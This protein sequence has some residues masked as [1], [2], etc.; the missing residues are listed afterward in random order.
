MI[1]LEGAG[2]SLPAAMTSSSAQLIAMLCK[3]AT[4]DMASSKSYT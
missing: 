3:A 4:E 1:I 2:M